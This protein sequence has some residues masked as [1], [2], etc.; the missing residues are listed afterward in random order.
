MARYTNRILGTQ[1]TNMTEAK[2]PE[3]SYNILVLGLERKGLPAPLEP[4]KA[5]NFSICFE[6]Y[7][8]ACRFQEFDG[9]IMFQGIFEKFEDRGSAYKSYFVHDYDVDELDKRKKEAALLLGQGGFLCFLLTDPFIDRDDRRD[10]SAT[11]LAK[12]H[13]NHSNFHRNNYRNRVAHVTPVIDEFRRFLDV[14]GAANSYF[15]NFN[16]ALDCRPLAKVDDENVGLLIEQ[17]EYFLPSLV[18]DARMEV[19]N[20]Y[21]HL[22]A[23]AITSVHNKLHQT[24][25][26][27]VAVYQ[28]KEEDALLEE[29]SALI[30]KVSDIDRRLAQLTQ[31]K[32]SLVHSG[33]QLVADVSAILETALGTKVNAT[34]EFREDV[35]LLDD[36]DNVIG[37]CEIK[38]INRGVKREN[39]NQTDSHRERSGFDADFPALLIVNTGIKSARSIDEKDQEIAAEQVKHAV[40]MRVLIMRTFDLLG[41]L[42]LV[43]AGDLSTQDARS[44][45]LSSIGWLRV[46]SDSV[47]VLTGQLRE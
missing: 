34:D 12:Y 21:F 14:F 16:N 13:L 7:G 38:G 2:S 39:I 25:P 1:I 3:R 11:D 46:Q 27:W 30:V 20:E 6:R 36:N 10:F 41:L 44:Q 29:R 35:K 40:H 22:L 28:F 42:R 18:P 33:P 45:V 37:V 17:S 43:L 19:I 32:A 4:L 8:T 23:D 15:R 47:Q 31:Y 26:D 9:V 5:Q 24:V